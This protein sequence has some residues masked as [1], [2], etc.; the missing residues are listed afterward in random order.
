[1]V[2]D[3]TVDICAG[4][5][6]LGGVVI[7]LNECDRQDPQPKALKERPQLP[8]TAVGGMA[9]SAIDKAE[10]VKTP[11]VETGNRIAETSEEGPP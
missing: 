6:L 9:R 5:L 10:G 2:D 1:M 11:I 4:L 3:E 7:S 8:E